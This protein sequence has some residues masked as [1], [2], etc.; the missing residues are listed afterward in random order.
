MPAASRLRPQPNPCSP[1]PALEYRS[2]A[3]WHRVAAPVTV[4]PRCLVSESHCKQQHIANARETEQRVF[5][6]SS[7]TRNQSMQELG[8]W[9]RVSSGDIR[10]GNISTSQREWVTRHTFV[11][12]QNSPKVTLHVIPGISGWLLP[13]GK[14]V[15]QTPAPKQSTGLPSCPA[16]KAACKQWQCNLNRWK[17]QTPWNSP[18]TEASTSNG[19]AQV[20]V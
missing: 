8:I 10:R 20:T 15:L 7:T 12:L 5:L 9:V 11:P 6:S 2:Q 13:P 4:S 17:P 1:P 14:S 19:K 18:K 3:G 16:A